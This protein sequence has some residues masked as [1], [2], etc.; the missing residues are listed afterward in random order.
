MSKDTSK[1]KI[2]AFNAGRKSAPS[3]VEAK[4]TGTAQPKP[5]LETW[6]KNHEDGQSVVQENLSL[7][8]QKHRLE[9]E[10]DE[11]IPS[12]QESILYYVSLGIA[13]LMLIA[14][15]AAIFVKAF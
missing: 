12:S 11:L 13:T 4:A 9:E 2:I 10:R 14:T 1:G 6:L 8:E 3:S 15:L 5:F 7:K